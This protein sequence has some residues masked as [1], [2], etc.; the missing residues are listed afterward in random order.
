MKA[1]KEWRN[2]TDNLAKAFAKKYFPDEPTQYNFWVGDD[3][4]GVF[5]VCEMFFDVD[6]MVTALELKA[7]FDQLYDYYHAEIDH[8]TENPEKPFRINFKNFVKYG[9]MNDDSK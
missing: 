9:W 7:T 8:A 5:C 1:I 4:G 2:A 3:I 6:R